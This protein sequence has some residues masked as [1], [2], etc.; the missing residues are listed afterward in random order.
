MQ[1][2]CVPRRSSSDAD[3]Q[4]RTAL[5]LDS[6]RDLRETCFHTPISIEPRMPLHGCMND[7]AISRKEGKQSTKLRPNDGTLIKAVDELS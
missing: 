3:K 4:R 1:H 7:V 5:L 2:A 6:C